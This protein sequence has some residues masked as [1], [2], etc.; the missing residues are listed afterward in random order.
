MGV[1]G[2][3]FWGDARATVDGSLG[4]GL[5]VLLSMLAEVTEFEM[6]DLE[7][8]SLDLQFSKLC[9]ACMTDT[10]SSFADFRI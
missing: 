10:A 2:A 8:L 4:G 7:K 6:L 9:G 1:G 5:T 3:R